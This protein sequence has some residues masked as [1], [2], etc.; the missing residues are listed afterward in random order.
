MHRGIRFR[1]RHNLGPL[2]VEGRRVRGVG[3]IS[4]SPGFLVQIP[5]S[6]IRTALS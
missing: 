6:L 2:R 4:A 1:Y 3:I 5:I